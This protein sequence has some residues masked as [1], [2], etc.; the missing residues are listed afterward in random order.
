M[1]K[2][3]FS[4]N[5]Y[6]KN[7]CEYYSDCKADHE[8]C[9][10]QAFHDILNELRSEE[11]QLIKYLYGY[12]G[13]RHTFV[14]ASREFGGN[15]ENYRLLKAKA[16]RK[17]RHPTRMRKVKD[18]AYEV[19]HYSTDNFYALILKEVF[20]Y[21]NE[22]PEIRFAQKGINYSTLISAS[23][24]EIEEKEI[25]ER[26]NT[27]IK[28]ISCLYTYAPIL[29][30]ANIISLNDL[31]N[32]NRKKL[33]TSVFDYNEYMIYDLQDALK[34][35][36]YRIKGKE[37][38]NRYIDEEIAKLIFKRVNR[39][40]NDEIAKIEYKHD[41]DLS[42]EL[43]LK[44]RLKKQAL[45]RYCYTIKNVVLLVLKE[46]LQERKQSG[47]R[48]LRSLDEKVFLSLSALVEAIK[49]KG[50]IL[51][52]TTIMKTLNTIKDAPIEDLN[53]SV[54]AYNCLKRA[55]YN[56]V[57]EVRMA[58]K[59][60]LMHIRNLGEG[61][62]EDT[63][64]K[65]DAFDCIASNKAIIEEYIELSGLPDDY[66]DFS[67]P[68]TLSAKLILAQIDSPKR[69]VKTSKKQLGK[70]KGIKPKEILLIEEILLKYGFYLNYQELLN[71]QYSINIL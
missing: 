46:Q 70:I 40:N 71:V 63:L 11:L 53:L 44:Y 35:M 66:T 8:N 47:Y 31:L 18:Y 32:Y 33:Y 62:L 67:L 48:L 10:K 61:S 29:E 52:I 57:S 1:K 22:Y 39:A 26:V 65:V 4:S 54:R 15:V 30:K 3:N 2:E 69:L 58:T 43:Y 55:G 60:E 24:T 42:C 9:I 5:T 27:P 12:D 36:G 7:K 25:F 37:G 14:E 6:C 38:Y 23:E 20:G 28:D 51:D 59:E 64:E 16:F 17:L 21:K 68:E 49:K 50:Y 19:F 41:R 56:K 45:E 34:D 13:K